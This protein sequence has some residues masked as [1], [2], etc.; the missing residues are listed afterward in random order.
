MQRNM[1][2]FQTV[3]SVASA[4]HHVCSALQSVTISHDYT[5]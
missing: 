1:V 3:N 2:F 5:V 4:K